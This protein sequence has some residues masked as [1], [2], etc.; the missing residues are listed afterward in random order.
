MADTITLERVEELAAQLPPQEQLK[1]V[2]RISKR[3]TEAVSLPVT[4]GKKE[5]ERLRRSD[6]AAAA[7]KRKTDAAETVRRIR[8]ERHR[9]L[10]R[11]A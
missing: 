4:I 5:M 3:L 1:L 2:T 9:E 8:E 6:R 11:S 7:F 10:W